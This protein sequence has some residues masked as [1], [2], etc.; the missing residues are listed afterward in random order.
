M[1]PSEF[2]LMMSWGTEFLQSLDKP[3]VRSKDPN[4]KKYP[5]RPYLLDK[6]L[7]KTEK[8]PVLKVL[9]QLERDPWL[10]WPRPLAHST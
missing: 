2:S 10:T 6:I 1:T 5:N 3:K 4:H 8:T 7:D 9:A